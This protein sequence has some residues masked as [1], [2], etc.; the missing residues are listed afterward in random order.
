MTIVN[1]FNWLKP[2]CI[3]PYSFVESFFFLKFYLQKNMKN[4]SLYSVSGDVLPSPR[5]THLD[6]KW[7]HSGVL[8]HFI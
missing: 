7:C 6:S 8:L 1:P 2:N 3:I 5:F 4:P